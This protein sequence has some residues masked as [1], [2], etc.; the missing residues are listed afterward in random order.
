M[1]CSKCG[2]RIDLQWVVAYEYY[3]EIFC[4]DCIAEVVPNLKDVIDDVEDKE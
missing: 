1:K 3:D 4:E 2:G